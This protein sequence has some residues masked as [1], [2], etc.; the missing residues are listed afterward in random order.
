MAHEERM[1]N[2]VE[3]MQA[4]ARSISATLA[5]V[6]KLKRPETP[7][8]L[9]NI[10]DDASKRILEMYFAIYIY[11]YIYIY[12]LPPLRMSSQNK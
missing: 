1:N 7:N 5:R 4:E 9:K 11:I 8:E 6:M 12:I 2:F 10:T 3:W